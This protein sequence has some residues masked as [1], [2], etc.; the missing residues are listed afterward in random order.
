[1][2]VE[3]AAIDRQRMIPLGDLAREFNS[4]HA[5]YHA[6]LTGDVFV[7]RPVARK[8]TYLDGPAPP[9]Q[10]RVRGVMDAGR[11]IFSPLDPRIDPPGARLGSFL[12][13]LDTDLG[14]NVDV[15]LDGRGRKAIDLLNDVAMKGPGHAWLVL[16]TGDETSRISAFGFI[17]QNG[18]TTELKVLGPR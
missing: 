11:K 8:A 10:V 17:H 9:L 1:M 13:G 15:Y 18:S 7:I 5:D 12:G 16:T 6:E 4:R 14:L 3:R 2:T